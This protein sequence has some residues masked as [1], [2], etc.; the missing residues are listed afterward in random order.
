VWIVTENDDQVVITR[1]ALNSI[2]ADDVLQDEEMV[3]VNV[4][5]MA[6]VF[7]SSVEDLIGVSN[8]TP[9]TLD[10]IELRLK[11]VIEQFKEIRIERIGGQLI[12]GEILE[13]RQHAVLKDRVVADLEIHLKIIA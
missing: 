13:V 2:A 9:S 12:E 3:R 8:V 4:D 11:G 10:L 7:R 6:K 1:H 5:S